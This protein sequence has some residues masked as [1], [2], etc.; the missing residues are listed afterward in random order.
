MPWVEFLAAV[1][2]RYGS[3]LTFASDWCGC[4]R[5]SRQGS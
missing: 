4:V 2:G 5:V 3:L 1:Q